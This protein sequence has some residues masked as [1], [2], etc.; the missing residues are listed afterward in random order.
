VTAGQTA[1]VS[2]MFDAPIEIA[3]VFTVRARLEHDSRVVAENDETAIALGTI[4]AK[5]AP[6]NT[7]QSQ[8]VTADL[9]ASSKFRSRASRTF[10]LNLTNEI[11]PDNTVYA[12]VGLSTVPNTAENLVRW[13]GAGRQFQA[14]IFGLDVDPLFLRGTTVEGASFQ[15]T[16][17]TRALKAL[18]VQ[19]SDPTENPFSIVALN[20]SAPAGPG[21]ATVTAGQMHV[22]GSV[23]DTTP[24]FLRDGLFAGA[25]YR[26][27]RP[28]GV[29]YEV[30][31]GLVTYHDDASETMRTD[32]M[33]DASLGFSTSAIVWTMSFDR[34]GTFFP[35]LASPEVTPDR[36][37]FRAGFRV[38]VGRLSVSAGVEGNRDGLD[39]DFSLNPTNGWTE[40]VQF[41]YPL[42]P[43]SGLRFGVL[44]AF[45]HGAGFIGALDDVQATNF[46]Y[47]TRVRGFTITTDIDS[48]NTRTASG[49][50]SHSIKDVIG[51]AREASEGLSFST[52][53]SLNNRQFNDPNQTE[54]YGAGTTTVSY[55]RGIFSLSAGTERSITRPYLGDAA[56]ALTT[57]EYSLRVKP[58]PRFPYGLLMTVGLQ[59]GFDSSTVGSLSL[60]R[61][62]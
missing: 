26:V 53:F 60:S 43:T 42:G 10:A 46:S 51:I 18:W 30:R 48:V 57:T 29:S 6:A 9:A 33:V 61:G 31:Y 4:A 54:I 28:A 23:D 34:T 52:G 50:L 56:P 49:V 35:S 17:N 5:A 20:Y 13:Q 2:V 19:S 11:S 40:R 41:A 44:N 22:S 38:P 36:E 62:F 1:F 3:D 55:A 7:A 47:A 45:G 59:H 15:Q 8:P 37:T 24:V 39:P 25:G 12:N 21:T 32:R 14:G 16:W 27:D 58:T